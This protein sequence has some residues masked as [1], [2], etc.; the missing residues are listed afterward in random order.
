MLAHIL[1]HCA[2]SVCLLWML[3]EVEFGNLQRNP[4][5]S[6]CFITTASVALQKATALIPF[7]CALNLCHGYVFPEQSYV[8]TVFENYTASFE[9]DSL[10]VELSLWDT[11]GKMTSF[12]RSS[13]WLRMPKFAKNTVKW[14]EENVMREVDAIEE[15]VADLTSYFY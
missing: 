2:L 8:P 1:F 5:S 7:P 15:R 14:Y 11:S 4:N 9:I 13:A 3:D 12:Q 10:R 6:I